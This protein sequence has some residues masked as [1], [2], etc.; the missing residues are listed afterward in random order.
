MFL[1]IFI[2]NL[3]VSLFLYAET[4][5]VVSCKI[6]PT[7]SFQAKTQDIKGDVVL[8]NNELLAKN[9]VVNLKSLSSG[10]GLRDNHM[11]NKY[12]E[13]QKFPEAVLELGKGKDGKGI[14][15]L[16][17]RGITKEIKGTYSVHGNDV[18][19]DF[20]IKLS[21][22]NISGIRYMGMGVKDIV[23]VSVT[24]PLKK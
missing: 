23:N 8:K 10:M 13:V 19:A 2:L 22:Y 7:G 17:I 16:K 6:S 3:F 4:G 15:K 9:V 18:K 1:K 5:V 20:P 21:D 11:K 24:M 14:G 12:L